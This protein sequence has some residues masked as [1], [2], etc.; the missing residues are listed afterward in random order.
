[1]CIS[2]QVV[3]HEISKKIVQSFINSGTKETKDINGKNEEGVLLF[4]VNQKNGQ[5]FS[6]ADAY[7]SE[8]VL[9]RKNLTIQYNSHVTKVMM[10][11]NLGSVT[12]EN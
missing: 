5:R 12:M 8:K 4:Q 10:E 6:T 2:D 11:K 1:M 3:P 9:K 7:L